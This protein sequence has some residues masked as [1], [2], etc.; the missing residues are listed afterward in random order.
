MND[1]LRRGLTVIFGYLFLSCL[2]FS[3]QD[4]LMDTVV[5]YSND[6][7]RE[8]DHNFQNF[9]RHEFN[10]DTVLG[11]FHNEEV[12]L[13]IPDLP[14]HNTVEVTFDLL[15]HDSWDGNPQN[16]GGPDKWYL[17]L[18]DE[19]IINTTFSNTPCGSSFCLYQAY[20]EYFPRTFEPKSGALDTSLPGR[21][22]YFGVPGWT[23]KYRITR[24]VKH[25]SSVLTLVCGDELLQL[26]A[27]DPTCDE[28]WSLSKIEVKTLT[29]K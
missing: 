12:S 22:Q 11:W 15:I 20:P 21:C 26:N 1:N 6:F 19:E 25:K 4:E 3:C 5:V 16:M 10:G 13:T 18:D 24:L 29:V 23:S 14:A 28:S 9:K 27:L 8:D 7:S 2:L 17:H